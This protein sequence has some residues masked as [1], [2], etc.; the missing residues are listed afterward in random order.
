MWTPPPPSV[1]TIL[2]AV[3]VL[4]A[5]AALAAY[6]LRHSRRDWPAI[7]TLAVVCLGFTLAYAQ[8]FPDDSY[9]TYRYAHNLLAGLGL[10]YNPGEHV[11][12]TT[13]PLYTLL[14]AAAGLVWPDLPY[15]SHI[16]S[17]PALFA[18][19]LALYLLCA[20]HSKPLAGLLLGVLTILNPLTAAVYSSE[21]IL[22]VAL[23]FG[24]LLAYDQNRLEWA[25]ALSALAVL[26]RGD[27]ALLG[28]ALALH[29][30]VTGRW[31][32]NGL[33]H[34]VRAAAVYVA[35][36]L[37]WYLF[38]WLYYG[39]PAPATLGAKMAQ[40][41][42]PGTTPFGVGLGFWWKSYSGQSILY[43]L[44]PPLALI[45]LWRILPRQGYRWAVPALLW[46]AMYTAGYTLLAV[47][48]YQN[49]YT[50]LAPALLLLAMLG[51]HWLGAA[52]AR[53]TRAPRLAAALQLVLGIGIG[54]GFGV[55]GA[56]LYPRLPQARA[57]VYQQIGEWAR[58]NTPPG[59][60]LGMYEVGTVGYYA[61]RRIIDFYGLIQPEVAEHIAHND[62]TWAPVHY[63]PDYIVGHP[64]WLFVDW[65]NTDPWFN[66]HYHEVKS[67]TYE[68]CD[69]SPM[70]V[71]GRN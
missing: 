13:T 19:A 2:A 46:A 36:A 62:Q 4:V 26:N 54:V 55:T 51:A 14:L 49:Y 8:F 61:D 53:G 56:A 44:I 32:A 25:A 60:S 5:S 29:W 23:I 3:L 50:P 35:V 70:V 11:L 21:S 28:I 1:T 10:V 40:A 16:L 67:F 31:R 9:I 64:D 20:R 52:L 17:L 68:R 7:A 71:Y 57:V 47:P 24:A 39:S 22:H 42:V 15:T 34:A 66:A 30:L 65:R 38:S 12:S 41:G 37:P 43:W 69:C 6:I 27:G 63:L 58:A 18:S 48:R 59:S 45:G 33:G